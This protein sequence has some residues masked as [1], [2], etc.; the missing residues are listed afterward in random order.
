MAPIPNRN[1]TRNSGAGKLVIS[2][3]LPGWLIRALQ[4]LPLKEIRQPLDVLNARIWRATCGDLFQRV[5][6]HTSCPSHVSPARF[7]P[8]Q[9]SQHKIEEVCGHSGKVDHKR[10]DLSTHIWSDIQTK[11]GLCQ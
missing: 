6:G 5:V 7:A 1:K 4:L 8:I 11:I 2:S 9:S 3:H 10:S